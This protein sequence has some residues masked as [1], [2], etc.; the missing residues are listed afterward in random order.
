MNDK[1]AVVAIMRHFDWDIEK[2]QQGWFEKQAEYELEIGLLYD[3]SLCIKP[4]NKN[5][6]ESRKSSCC[7]ICY[8]D[9]D[10]ND[11]DFK[12]LH[13]VCGHTFHKVCWQEYLK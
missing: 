2:M 10:P 1:D 13:L 4:K 11:E 5:I 6:N 7:S 12:P 9:Y 3:E 8:L